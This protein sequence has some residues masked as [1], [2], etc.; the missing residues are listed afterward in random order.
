M[1]DN[2]NIVYADFGQTNNTPEKS[3]TR[4]LEFQGEQDTN[5]LVLLLRQVDTGKIRYQVE[6]FIGTFTRERCDEYVALYKKSDCELLHAFIGSQCY[7]MKYYVHQ[8]DEDN[9]SDEGKTN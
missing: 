8:D 2:S 3:P 1:S 9:D 7:L 5:D 6:K 4:N